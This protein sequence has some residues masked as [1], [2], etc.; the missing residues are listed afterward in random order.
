MGI[1]HAGYMGFPYIGDTD[2]LRQLNLPYDTLKQN[3][4][5]MNY[6]ENLL[7][8]R[9]NIN[10]YS[11]LNYISPSGDA[12]NLG[13][14]DDSS[15]FLEGLALEADFSPVSRLEM[16]RRI[17]KGIIATHIHGSEGYYNWKIKL[18]GKDTMI[19]NSTYDA[20]ASMGSF[21][22]SLEP[23]V[24]ISFET[25]TPF[26]KYSYKD[27][28]EEGGHPI[29]GLR[30][31]DNW[32]K[33][34]YNWERYYTFEDKVVSGTFTSFNAV[35]RVPV[36]IKYDSDDYKSITTVIGKTGE[37]MPLFVWGDDNPINIH[38]P[39]RKTVYKSDIK[40][41]F[42]L[43]NPKFNYVI[44]TKSP[45]WA[46]RGYATG[47]MI[48]WEDGAEKVEFIAG[49][50]YEQVKITQ[51]SGKKVF[52]EFY[53]WFNPDEM[54][55][56]FRNAEVFL[57][58][59]EF[60]PTEYM[61][62]WYLNASYTGLAAG[63]YMMT[64]WKDPYAETSLAHATRSIDRVMEELRNGKSFYRPYWAVRSTAWMIKTAKLLGNKR[65]EA[66]YTDDM[67]FAIEKMNEFMKDQLKNWGI[68]WD[69]WNTI[70]AY[71]MAYYATYDPIYKKMWDDSLVPITVDD[72]GIYAYGKALE[73]PGGIQTYF[74]SMAIGA[75]GAAGMLDE[76]ET[77]MHMNVPAYKANLWGDDQLR[78]LPTVSEMWSDAGSG[79]W[80]QDDANPEYV[81]YCL[82]GLNV[83]RETK[84]IIPVGYF[85]SYDINGNVV[86]K[87]EPLIDNQ[88][89]VY[90]NDD[91]ITVT[92]DE[93]PERFKV[94]KSITQVNKVVSDSKAPLD[95]KFDV[96]NAN[97]GLAFDFNITGNG[98][99][100]EVSPDGKQWFRKYDTKNDIPRPTSIDVSNFV[101]KADEYTKSVS[102]YGDN[103]DFIVS[104]TGSNT[105]GKRRYIADGKEVIYLFDL[106]L[107]SR[108]F[109]EVF[110]GNNYKIELS[111]DNENWK[112]AV[113]SNYFV[114]GKGG[115]VGGW[116]R[117][118]SFDEYISSGKVYMKISNLSRDE[119]A[120]PEL[121]F[122]GTAYVQSLN[123]Y[124]VYDVDTLYMRI[125]NVWDTVSKEFNLRSIVKR[126]W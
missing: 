47:I 18:V 109:I 78:D 117:L 23:I 98:Y 21:G 86:L 111:S 28:V 49:K 5:G 13:F 122:P 19:S 95:F 72:K 61:A 3:S 37:K 48:F 120:N 121:S 41:S 52:L 17:N 56:L 124:S 2:T 114:T 36:E 99:I 65:M 66:K 83:P 43:K 105:D 79:P 33:S 126:S 76:C 58:T 54:D 74:G 82:A 63:A 91:L 101:G 12:F 88:F 62:P 51:K 104:D 123:L 55:Y 71:F 46:T 107:M 57:E 16:A 100:I 4:I 59:G 20:Y 15:R 32:N 77:Y 70:R 108:A 39:D 9:V 38:L 90:G 24:S 119:L 68:T 14:P 25:D 69:Y 87:N 118:V 106:S 53:R 40:G 113:D 64:K 89:F 94:S 81:G 75:F 97:N 92:G 31:A 67:E 45:A 85:S 30:S 125:S 115:E 34:P 27:R 35:E 93:I 50:G 96:K 10:S 7:D 102:I 110:M 1:S 22:D 26:S 112:K 116:Q 80:A 11:H 103:K 73:D 6:M 8:V 29:L 42:T 60:I 84:Y 44:M